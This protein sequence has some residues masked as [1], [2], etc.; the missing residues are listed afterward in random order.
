L[1]CQVREK[2]VA[3]VQTKTGMAYG[4]VEGCRAESCVSPQKTVGGTPKNT[5]EKERKKE[6]NES[7]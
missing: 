5:E 2:K 7:K 3:K 4:K 1:F 6:E